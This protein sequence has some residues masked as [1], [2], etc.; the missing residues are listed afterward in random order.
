MEISV[1]RDRLATQEALLEQHG[2]IR[3]H[4]IEAYNPSDEEQVQRNAARTQLIEH[5]LQ[6]LA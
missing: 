1:L 4:E 6:D 2:V 3:R 5:L